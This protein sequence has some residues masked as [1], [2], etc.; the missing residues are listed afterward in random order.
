MDGSITRIFDVITFQRLRYPNPAAMHFWKDQRQTS[1]GIEAIRDYAGRCSRWLADQDLVKGDSIYIL[2]SQASFSWFS[3]DFGCQMLGVVPVIIPDYLPSEEVKYIVDSKKS[4]HF[5]YQDSTIWTNV[6]VY[7]KSLEISCIALDEA[8]DDCH[9]V[10]KN[11]LEKSP[12]TPDDVIA[13]WCKNIHPDDTAMILATSGSTGHPKC[14]QLSHSNVVS[15]IQAVLPLTPLERHHQVV[16]FLPIVHIF[17]RMVVYCYLTSGASIHFF[18]SAGE[19]FQEIQH[20]RPHFFSTVPR[21]LE[22]MYEE[23]LNRIKKFPLLRRLWLHMALETGSRY[24]YD[25]RKS[26][27]YWIKWLFIELTVFRVWRKRIGGRV[28]GI[29]VGAAPLNPMLGRVLSAARIRVREGYGMTETS[30]VISFN[31]FEAGGNRFGS[32]G[33]PIPGIRVRISN[34]NP[35]GIGEIEVQGPNVMQGYLDPQANAAAFTP[36]GW[37]RTGDLGHMVQRRFLEITDRKA[38]A[39]K[40]SSGRFVLP[41]RISRLLETDPLISGSI[42]IGLQRPY[43]TALIYPEFTHLQ[44]WCETNGVHWTAPAYMIHNPRVTNCYSKLVEEVNAKLSRHEQI[45]R[46]TLLPVR[47]QEETVLSKLG[48]PNHRLIREKYAKEIDALYLKEPI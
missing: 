22:R 20:V 19:A 4:S 24:G 34:P 7:L 12:P 6:S 42:I 18:D 14:V 32:A 40:T 44:W 15:N 11:V 8:G 3:L 16:S 30:P 1:Y 27:V 48:K 2:A 37:L 36:D 29:I 41:E 13:A 39:F 43:V 38:H 17:E 46:F 23:L 33:I 45:R 21:I 10:L 47:W 26:P 5:F 9:P 25:I 31:R 35:D 28:A